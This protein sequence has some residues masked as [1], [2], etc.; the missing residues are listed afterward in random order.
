[1]YLSTLGGAVATV[2]GCLSIA[3]GSTETIREVSIVEAEAERLDIT[4]EL[5][6]R[7][8][9]KSNTAKLRLKWSNPSEKEGEVN[10]DAKTPTPLYSHRKNE[11]ETTGL[12]LVPNG[13]RPEKENSCWK[14]ANYIGVQ[15][16][17][18]STFSSPEESISQ[19]YTLWTEPDGEGCLRPGRYYFGPITSETEAAPGSWRVTLAVGDRT[20]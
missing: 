8:V 12:M 1:V 19:K 13:R 2:S 9:T 16:D 18:R 11:N 3:S 20:E 10:V 5:L 7:D 6:K 17:P 14:A 15:A 4:A